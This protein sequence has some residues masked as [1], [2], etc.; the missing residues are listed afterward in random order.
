MRRFLSALLL[1][2][3]ALSHGM[4]S[5]DVPHA[6]GTVHGSSLFD[7]HELKAEMAALDADETSSTDDATGKSA[8]A[9]THHVHISA[10]AVPDLAI[11]IA[12]PIVEKQRQPLLDD[13][14][15]RSTALAP[16]TEPPSA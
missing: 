9:L 12:A 10:D 16:P 1:V 11:M 14:S 6:D 8:P 2:I 13:A 3:L 15:L 5:A 7:H 4:A